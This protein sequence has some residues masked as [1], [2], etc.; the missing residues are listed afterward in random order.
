MLDPVQQ[1]LLKM[2]ADSQLQSSTRCF[3]YALQWGHG[4]PVCICS[5]PLQCMGPGTWDYFHVSRREM[6]HA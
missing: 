5:P 3:A 1:K 2:S 4:D 6:I